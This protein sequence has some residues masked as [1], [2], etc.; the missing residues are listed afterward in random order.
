MDATYLIKGNTFFNSTGAT[1]TRT[2]GQVFTDTDETPTV[3]MTDVFYT[4]NSAAGDITDFDDGWQ[5]KIITVIG[6]DTGLTTIVHNAAKI[7]LDGAADCV[8]EDN[9]AIQ[10][11]YDGTDWNEV[12]RSNKFGSVRTVT[13]EL[14]TANIVDLADTPITLVAAQGADTLIEFISAYLILDYSGGAL[15]EPSAPDDLVIEYDDGDDVSQEVDATGFIDQTNDE[16]RFVNSL[17]PAADPVTA[18][19][20]DNKNDALR[21]FNTGSDY[22]IGASTSTMTVKISYRVHGLGL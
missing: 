3:F 9:D 5:S 8:L 6:A 10:L 18:D 15:A 1:G 2:N 17:L 20:N 19:L 4:N 12:S 16:I 13:I 22:T 21:L 7:N 11:E 14:T